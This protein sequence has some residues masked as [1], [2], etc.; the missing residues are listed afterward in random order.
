MI[1][2]VEI[3]RLLSADLFGRILSSAYPCGDFLQTFSKGHDK[4]HVVLGDFCKIHLKVEKAEN[5]D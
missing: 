1:E 4:P 5:L 2:D 3:S